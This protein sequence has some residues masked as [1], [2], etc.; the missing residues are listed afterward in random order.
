MTEF[1]W[2]VKPRV[3]DD[4]VKQLLFNR[5]IIGEKTDEKL[6]D[7]F[8]NPNFETDFH[9]PELLP[10][11]V[12]FKNRIKRAYD[13]HEKI[14]VFG[15]YDAD[16][17]PGSA[18]LVKALTKIGI[19]T[20]FYIPTRDEGYGLNQEGIDYLISGGCS[21]IITVDLGIRSIELAEYCRSKKC[22][23]I[24][25]DHHIPGDKIP[26][27]VAVINPK[28]KASKYPFSELS[29]AGV[30]F[31]LI[32]GLKKTFPEKITDRFLKWNL[33]LIAI[34]TISDVVPL[35]NEN[36]V[37]AKFGLITLQKTKNLGLEKMYE[38]S[39]IKT[40]KINSYTVGFQIAPRI[41]A[42]GRIDSASKSFELLL[43][44]NEKE[45]TELAKWLNDQNLLRQEAMD[46]VETEVIEMIAKEK[47]DKDMIIIA[48]GQWPRGVIGPT[49]SR[50]V[51]KYR[52]PVILL[53]IEEEGLIGS[54][55][56]VGV[57]NMIENLEKTAKWLTKFGGHKGAA[58]LS[59]N[60]KN[61]ESF[62]K[63]MIK[64]ANTQI[65]REDLIPKLKI[66]LEMESES[67]TISK[68][69]RFL[70]L[71]PFGLG[72]PKPVFLMTQLK[73]VEQRF[74]GRDSRHLKLKFQSRDRDH[75]CIYFNFGEKEKLENKKYYDIIFTLGVDEWNGSEKVSLSITDLKLSTNQSSHER[76]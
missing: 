30:V 49:A 74:V 3:F 10:D 51:E 50:L 62:E 5:G 53:A 73:L 21:L 58:G 76:Q 45:A 68:I 64:L 39:G 67:I 56:S 4:E 1:F 32:Q 13:N 52:R 41:N 70:E 27:A 11:F 60:I 72:N 14:G 7:R 40:E 35:I 22:D 25:T 59:L 42:P 75:D 12:K 48:S 47:L 63:A 28:L 54:S 38:V 2:E 31:K 57:F 19:E 26:Q 36:R 66:D 24:I 33:D 6:V 44:E 23:L 20:F 29:G 18:F 65:S 69:K 55:R 16:G 9:N 43:T 17:I 15:D 8:I 61:L 34:S 37:I 46:Q 71:E